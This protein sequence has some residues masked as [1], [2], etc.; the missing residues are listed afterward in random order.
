MKNFEQAG[1]IVTVA[2]PANVAS[3]QLFR[4]GVLVG[5]AQHAA[6]SGQPVEMATRGVFRVTKTG[7]QA[8]TVGAAIFGT[9]SNTLT[10]TTAATSGNILVG[11][12]VEAVG[13]GAG[14]TTGLVRL[15]GSAPAAVV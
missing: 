10:A 13:S 7:S 2:A 14:E 5:V 11:T 6:L 8:W 3:G 12:A 15:N 9:G 4:V 1:D